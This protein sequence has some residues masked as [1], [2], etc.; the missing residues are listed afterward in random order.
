MII[1]R[2]FGKQREKLTPKLTFNSY[3]RCKS[4]NLSFLMFIKEVI[5]VTLVTICFGGN[6]GSWKRCL[7]YG[8]V[9]ILAA[10]ARPSL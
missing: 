9:E 2:M 5:I 6:M 4:L 10:R 3:A 8:I 7:E 1:D